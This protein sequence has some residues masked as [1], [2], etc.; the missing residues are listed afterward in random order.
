M[1]RKITEKLLKWKNGTGQRLP[2][3]LYGARQVGKTYILSEFAKTFYKNSVYIN[4]EKSSVLAGFFDG[5]LSPSRLVSIFESHFQ[6][7][8]T[9]GETLI[10]F[11]EIQACERAL[12]SL[13]YFA[14]DAP[15][16]HVAAAGSLL[17]VAINREKHSFPVGKVEMLDLYPLD[18]EEFLIASG[19]EHFALMIREHFISNKPVNEAI[20]KELIAIYKTYLAVGGMPMAVK[21]YLEGTS[22]NSISDIQNNIL[23]SYIAD[24][25]KYATNSDSVKIRGCFESI[26][27]QLAKENRKFQY[28]LVRKGATSTLFGPSI[29]WLVMAGIVLKCS[30]VE[31]GSMPLSVFRDLS[32]FKLYMS[33]TGL[34]CAKSGI[35]VENIQSDN[36]IDVIKG[37]ICENFVAQSLVSNGYELYYWESKYQAEI[38]FVIQKEGKIIPVEVKY[39]TNVRS[40]SLNAFVEKYKPEYSMRISSRNFGLENGIK[41]VPLYSVFAV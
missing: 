2:V 30:K 17:G 13:K 7:K 9:D 5:D 18:F 8:I 28:K 14:E 29:D 23:D 21:N 15:G 26:P 25:S 6:T 12:T 41:S 31:H 33:D 10:I 19:K 38:D 37:A 11:D 32:A 16:L 20:H 4:F 27:A 35:A 24:M 1:K 22:F 39:S 36:I 34:Y 40:K 3:L